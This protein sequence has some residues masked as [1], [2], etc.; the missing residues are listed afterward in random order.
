MIPGLRT[1]IDLSWESVWHPS[2]DAFNCCCFAAV[3]GR[4]GMGSTYIPGQ[5]VYSSDVLETMK[6]AIFVRSRRH[7]QCPV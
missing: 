4:L 3:G 5:Y 6:S 2:V 7:G 1:L